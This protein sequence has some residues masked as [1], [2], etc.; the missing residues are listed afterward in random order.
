ML[1]SLPA[2]FKDIHVKV[3]VAAFQFLQCFF[4]SLTHSF[5]CD[6]IFSL[7]YFCLIVFDNFSLNNLF[8]LNFSLNDL[9]SFIVVTAILTLTIVVS[10]YGWHLDTPHFVSWF[11]LVSIVIFM[12]LI[13]I[14]ALDAIR[15]RHKCVI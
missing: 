6:K 1:Q 12:Y 5:F 13:I 7:I 10:S 2:H 4:K 9:F 14:A 11:I 15:R 3:W 8:K